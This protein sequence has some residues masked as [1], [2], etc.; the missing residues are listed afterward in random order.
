[1]VVLILM[2]IGIYCLVQ[3]CKRKQAEAEERQER[4]EQE[5]QNVSPMRE[6]QVKPKQQ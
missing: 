5:M 4:E 1:V 3:Y 2:G 6:Q